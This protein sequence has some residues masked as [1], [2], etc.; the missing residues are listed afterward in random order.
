MYGK[1][2]SD[3]TQSYPPITWMY[4]PRD[5]PPRL[6]TCAVGGNSAGRGK[7]YLVHVMSGGVSGGGICPLTMTSARRLRSLDPTL[8][9]SVGSN[10]VR[11]R[12]L[13]LVDRVCSWETLPGSRALE[14]LVTRPI[15][16]EL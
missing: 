9:E 16:A 5:V 7:G 8:Q 10:E 6:D 14:V 1:L 11:L 3:H 13:A 4:P 12:V 15:F 2:L